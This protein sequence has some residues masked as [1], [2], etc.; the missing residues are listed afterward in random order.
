M[1][2]RD[3]LEQ[4][5]ETVQELEFASEARCA[6]GVLLLDEEATRKAGVYLLGYAAEML[7]KTA[8]FRFAKAR[9]FDPVAPLLDAAKA[10]A[11]VFNLAED[12]EN[13]HNLRFWTEL[14]L[15]TRSR[16]DRRLPKTLE[17]ELRGR[18]ARLHE[19]WW[20]EMRYRNLAFAKQEALFVLRDVEWVRNHHLSLW[21]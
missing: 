13:Y 12:R 6:E 5:E 9:S 16:N 1:A 19:N 14:L 7:F 21:R 15:E 10:K 8:Y 20:V 11:K 4:I 2:F 3:R 17:D 18:A